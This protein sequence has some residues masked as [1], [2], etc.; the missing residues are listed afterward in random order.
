MTQLPPGPPQHE[1]LDEPIH[2]TATAPE[3]KVSTGTTEPR[4]VK[5]NDYLTKRFA[6]GGKTRNYILHEIERLVDVGDFTLGKK[7]EQ[8]EAE[9]ANYLGVNH[10]IGTSNGT[11]ALFLIFD[12]IGITHVRMPALTFW[13]TAGAAAQ[14]GCQIIF[15]DVLE[16]LL[17]EPDESLEFK[18]IRPSSDWM[19][20]SEQ[21]FRGTITESTMEYPPERDVSYER[22]KLATVPVW[23][24]G[25][26]DGSFHQSDGY[27]IEDAAQAIG[28]MDGRVKAGTVGYAAAFSLHPLKNICVWGDGGFISTNDQGLA[29]EIRL[30]RNHGMS[31]RDTVGVAGYNM[32]LSPIQAVV[33]LSQMDP[34]YID[35]MTRQRNEVAGWYNKALEELGGTFMN[36]VNIDLIPKR[37]TR[38]AYHL[39]QFRYSQNGAPGSTNWRYKRS[40][41][42]AHLNECGIEARIHYEKLV[43]QQDAYRSAN[44]LNTGE[45]LFATRVVRELVSLP[46]HEY[47]TEEDVAYVAAKIADFL[48]AKE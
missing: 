31:D 22:S 41:L 3:V 1:D 8:F 17:L 36:K 4:F 12:A 13:A 16:D 26:M 33:A 38:P 40:A 42:I 18:F 47:I 5:Q 15:D 11:D 27:V 10:V 7:V 43:S 30:L 34:G 37:A 2:A 20:H 45:H 14:A 21:D 9:M 35:E 46:M 6:N 48:D 23:W 19:I 29:E 28:A 39:Y 24:A 25:D 44:N 32:R